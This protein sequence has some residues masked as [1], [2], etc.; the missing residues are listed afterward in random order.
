MVPTALLLY[1]IDFSL[2]LLKITIDQSFSN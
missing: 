1:D 2:Q